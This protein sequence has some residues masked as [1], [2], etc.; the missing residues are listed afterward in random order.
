MSA[1]R[2]RFPLETFSAENIFRRADLSEVYY[3][4]VT[5]LNSTKCILKGFT[6]AWPLSYNGAN[7]GN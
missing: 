4:R 2:N 3:R 7:H 5:D 6:K 1:H